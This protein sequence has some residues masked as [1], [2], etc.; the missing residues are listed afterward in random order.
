MK[1]LVKV[2]LLVIL[3]AVFIYVISY[4]WRAFPIISGYGAKN[5]C[6]CVYVSGRAPESAIANELGSFPLSLGTFYVDPSDS[7]AYGKVFGMAT[8][9]A[10]YRKGLGCTLLSGLDEGEVRG[11]TYHLPKFT[12][13]P[14]TLPWPYGSQ[15]RDTVPEGVD[16]LALKT[17]VHHAFKETDPERPQNTRGVVVVYDGHLL[18]EQYAVG[19]DKNTPQ[20]GWSMTKSITNALVGILVK[21]GALNIYEPA[22]VE[23]WQS[24]GDPRSAITTDQLLRMSSGLYWEEEYGGPSA[25]TDMLFKMADM[26]GYAAS[27]PLEY[28][29]DAHW[30]YSSGT[31][32]ILSKIIRDHIKKDTYYA[33]VR[34]RLFNKLGMTSVVVEPDASGTFVGSSYAYATPGDWAKFGLLYLNDGVWKGERILPEGWVKYSSTPTPGAPRGE[35]GAHFWLNAGPTGSPEDRWYPDA[36]TDMFSMNGY[37][38]QRVFIIPS[39]KVIIVRTGLT[40]RGNFDFNNFL[41]EIL[42]AL[43][44]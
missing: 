31:S 2:L 33:F 38:G 22:P 13:A 28:E 29:P 20:M 1:K 3:L 14:D 4:A 26:G 19:F 16:I 41:K 8:K 30:Y 34:T 24:A 23:Q 11:Q 17:V 43:P 42:A 36:P 18:V 37:E 6:S 32:N 27:Y 40:K 9:K 7:S 35:Y 44:E 15:V 5:L 10:I 21:D 25:A 39:K 12:S